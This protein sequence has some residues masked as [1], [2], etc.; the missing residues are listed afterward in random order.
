L[1]Y[2]LAIPKL[3][4]HAAPIRIETLYAQPGARLAVGAK[5]ADISMD[6]SHLS[7]QNCPPIS[8]HRIVLR[9]PLWLRAWAA[10]PG[11][12]CAQSD[13]IAIFSDDEAEPAGGA[14]T[15][16]ARV[17]TAGITHHPGMW[18]GDGV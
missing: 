10:A 18:T 11:Q 7:T 15:R 9:E 3:N 1:L 5:L 12:L 17:M 8:F 4:E 14:I 2:S 13:C 6:F 16:S